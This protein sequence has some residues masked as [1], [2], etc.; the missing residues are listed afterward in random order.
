MKNRDLKEDIAMVIFFLGFCSIPYW[1][2]MLLSCVIVFCFSL[3]GIN[4]NFNVINSIF[5]CLYSFMLFVAG[6]VLLKEKEY[7]YTYIFPILCFISGLI[8][9]LLLF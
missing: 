8:A 3:F 6:I 7:K 4:L 9:I 1:F 5:V 2:P